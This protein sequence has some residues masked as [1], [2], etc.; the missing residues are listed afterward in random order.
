MIGYFAKHNNPSPVEMAK[1]VLATDNPRLLAAIAVAGEHNTPYQTR[2]GGYKKQHAGAWQVNKKMHRKAY[3]P[4]PTT[5]AGQ[6]L[7]A[8][9]LLKDLLAEY[10][11]KKALSIY[12]G[13]ST[14]AY[15]RRV[16]IALQETP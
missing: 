16:L 13:D 15:Q 4:V 12:G 5:P 8:D 1:A 7:Q 11:T 10:P 14:D 9:R 6:A 2:N 3:G